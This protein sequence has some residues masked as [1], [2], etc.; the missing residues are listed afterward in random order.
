MRLAR[1]LL[2][3]FWA[4]LLVTLGAVVAPTLFLTLADPHLAGS[5]AGDLFRLATVASAAIAA[6]LLVLGSR[7]WVAGV[8]ARQ[9]AAIGPAMLLSVSEWFVR[10]LIAAARV[11]GGTDTAAFA[12]WHA[13][14]SGLYWLAALW[15]LAELVRE[16]RG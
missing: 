11:A 13:V 16:L 5:I 3:A 12:T 15:V 2:L 7:T 10:P 8:G 1:R 14:S 6:A 4:G 9:A